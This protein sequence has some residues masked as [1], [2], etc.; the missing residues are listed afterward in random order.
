MSEQRALRHGTRHMMVGDTQLANR[1]PLLQT[2][3]TFN[4]QGEE[5]LIHADAL[6]DGGGESDIYRSTRSSD[7]QQFAAKIYCNIAVDDRTIRL[8]NEICDLV[9]THNDVKTWHL[10]PI[11]AHGVVRISGDHGYLYPKFVEIMPLLT[12]TNHLVRQGQKLTAK[13]IREKW[14]PQL[15]TAIN[16]LHAA[17]WLHRDI[18]PE[19]LYQLD[20]N[21]ALGDFGVSCKVLPDKTSI[22]VTTQHAGTPGYVAPEVTSGYATMA[23]DCY[24]L[25][26]TLVTLCLG[27]H[28]AFHPNVNNGGNFAAAL[29]TLNSFLGRGELPFTSG[30]S[31]FDQLLMG[32]LSVSAEHRYTLQNVQDYCTQKNWTAPHVQ[33]VGM[34]AATFGGEVFTDKVTLA[35]AMAKKWGSAKKYLYQGGANNSPFVNDIKNTDGL[36]Q[37]A[38]GIIADTSRDN[39][40]AG[41][42]HLL[43]RMASKLGICWKGNNYPDLAAVASALVVEEKDAISLLTSGVLSHPDILAGDN[44]EDIRVGLAD[45]A[46]HAGKETTAEAARWVGAFLLG[47]VSET[48]LST[49]DDY[50]QQITRGGGDPAERLLRCVEDTRQLAW[51]R[52][53]AGCDIW[54]LLDNN[55]GSDKERLIRIYQF[56]ESYCQ[57]PKSFVS[58]ISARGQMGTWPGCGTI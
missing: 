43:H 6:V 3:V 54:K 35:Q 58:T 51:L 23:T 15:A 11:I 25:G 16:T 47:H 13:A 29:G 17:N 38:L 26:S 9:M 44:V 19:N 30:D 36:G 56:F 27:Q 22:H 24:S 34:L 31:R 37:L 40:D 41:L 49:P 55:V 18:K 33:R 52:V 10:M 39:E 1:E 12:S 21:L 28:Y 14:L 4:Y 8:R 57:K 42:T 46:Q 45:V 48:L 50:F 5:H 20:G 7:G 32:L 2:D 53:H